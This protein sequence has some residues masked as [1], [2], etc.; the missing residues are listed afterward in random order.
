M[1]VVIAATLTL[2]D[3]SAQNLISNPGF[4]QTGQGICSFS[5]CPCHSTHGSGSN[6]VGWTA[7][8]AIAGYYGHA[9]KVDRV[10]NTPSC[11]PVYNPNGGVYC[12]DLQGSQ[13]CGCN[14]NGGVRQTVS[15]TP[16][17]ITIGIAL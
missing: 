16:G 5:A 11:N 13:C 6:L 12:I 14:N 2:R 1:W 9:Y 3:A 10:T 7:T 17:L 8:S 15:V 4:E